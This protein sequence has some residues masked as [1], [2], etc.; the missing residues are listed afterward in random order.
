MRDGSYDDERLAAQLVV[1]GL[2]NLL[3]ITVVVVIVVVGLELF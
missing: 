2:R 3:V 1:S